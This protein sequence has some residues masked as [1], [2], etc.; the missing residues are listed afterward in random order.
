MVPIYQGVHGAYIPGRLGYIHPGRL[1]YIHP[2]RLVYPPWEA[3]VPPWEA[4]V[5]TM[6]G[7]LGMLHT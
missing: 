4:S 2:G 1:G 5:P 6:G 3:S 7:I